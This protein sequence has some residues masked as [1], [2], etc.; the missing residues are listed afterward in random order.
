MS[1]ELIERLV[2]LSDA[3]LLVIYLLCGV[4]YW[5]V[6]SG[7]VLRVLIGLIVDVLVLRSLL[8]FVNGT[9]RREQIRRLKARFQ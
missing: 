4:G 3:I 1:D 9:G 6:T 7:G 5:F 8:L 2:T